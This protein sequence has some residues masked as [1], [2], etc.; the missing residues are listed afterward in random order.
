MSQGSTRA[1]Y[2]GSGFMITMLPSGAA[3]FL[4][5]PI[6]FALDQIMCVLLAA[7]VVFMGLM[8]VNLGRSRNR[9]FQFEEEFVY[10]GDVYYVS[11]NQEEDIGI[12]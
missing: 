9:L 7:G 8:C 6:F 5:S 1:L 4:R 10:K 12:F 3:G 2:H 11:E